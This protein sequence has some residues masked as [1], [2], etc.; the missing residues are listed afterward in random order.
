MQTKKYCFC[1]E[2]RKK[3]ETNK[4]NQV[5]TR[6]RMKKGKKKI[7]TLS[8]SQGTKNEEIKKEENSTFS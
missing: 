7:F 8:I 1:S 2:K 6:G 3:K 5:E 4:R